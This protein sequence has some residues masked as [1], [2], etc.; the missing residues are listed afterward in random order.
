MNPSDYRTFDDVL[1]AVEDGRIRPGSIIETSTEE[2]EL[3][4]TK[5][6]SDAAELL[7]KNGITLIRLANCL[8]GSYGITPPDESSEDGAG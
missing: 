4:T 8:P 5:Q 7:H 2:P 6:I 3:T 1:R